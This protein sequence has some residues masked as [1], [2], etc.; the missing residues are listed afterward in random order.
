V[1]RLTILVSGMVAGT[2]NHGG[3]T[4]AVLQYLLGLK[5]L[6]HDVVFVEQCDPGSLQPSGA[7]LG[8]SRNAAYFRSAMDGAGL[9]RSS[10]MLLAGTLET[11]GLDYEALEERVAHSDLLLN[12]SGILTDQSLLERIPRRAYL[13]LDPAFTQ[14]WHEE[15][16]EVR[17]AGH[18]HYVTVGQAIGTN[19][20]SIPTGGL[21]WTVM[22]PPVVLDHWPKAQEIERDAFTTVGNWRGYGSIERDG[23]HY[24]QK[25][26]SLRNFMS[27]PKDTGE[28]FVLAL[29]IHEDEKKDLAALAE[30]GWEVVDP[31]EVA[32]TPEEYRRFIQGSRAEFGIAKSGYVASRCGWFSDRSAC[33][34]ASGRPVLAQ[35]TGFS[36]FLPTGEGL[37]AFSTKEDVAGAIEELNSD[38]ERH[39][40]S[41]RAI[42]EEHLDSDK[43]LAGLLD[44]VTSEGG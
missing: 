8:R 15:G 44:E 18:T 7:S 2:P 33:Y 11:V 22:A 42:A 41:A 13:D 9:E 39:S 23:V 35:E 26:H 36:R 28:R 37:F 25:A 38:Y 31:S 40:R 17:L 29:S 12:I 27:L 3:A 30:N 14:V 21:S 4:W 5:R 6:G 1:S 10:A 32:G 16:I 24:G 34:L 43:V 19:H 20:S